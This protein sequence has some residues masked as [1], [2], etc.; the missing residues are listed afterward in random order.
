MQRAVRGGGDETGDPA[1]EADPDRTLRAI[2][3]EVAGFA[4]PGTGIPQFVRRAAVVAK[5]G[6]YDLAVHRDEVVAP[7]LRY[8]KVFEL[9]GLGAEGEKARDD[10]SAVLAELDRR[11][12]R[13]SS[14]R[15]L[16]RA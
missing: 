3:E 8:W 16:V 11:V 10:L 1:L 14:R 12:S 13:L 4:M 9:E 2:T 15:E 6:I 5:A 7:L